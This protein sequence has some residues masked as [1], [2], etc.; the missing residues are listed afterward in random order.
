MATRAVATKTKAPALSMSKRQAYMLGIIGEAEKVAKIQNISIGMEDRMSS[1][2]LCLDLMLGKG[3]LAPGMYTFSGGEQ[4]CK[5]TTQLVV[6][7]ASVYQK[8]EM[9]V[10]WDAE[11]SS[12]SS[13]DYVQ[14]VVNTVLRDKRTISV[15]D[16]FGVKNKKGDFIQLPVV[17]YQDTNSLEGFFDFFAALLRRL[18]DKRYED[19]QWWYIFPKDTKGMERAKA[20]DLEID[21]ARSKANGA[22]YAPAEDGSP[23]ALILNDGWAAM[24]PEAMDEEEKK[25]GLGL[26]ARKFAEHLPRVKGKLRAKRVILIGTNQ[27]KEKPMAFGD[28]RY[29]SGGNSLRFNSDCRIWHTARALSGVPYKPK[30]KGMIEE[31]DSVEFPGTKDVY[32]YVSLEARKNKLGVP[33]RTTWIKVWISDGEGKARGLCPVFDTFHALVETGQISGKLTGARDK[34]LL[35]VNSLGEAKKNINWTEFKTLILGTRKEMDTVLEKIG[36]KTGIG[37]RAGLF[38]MSRRGLLEELY[39]AR[40]TGANRLTSSATESAEDLVDEEDE[41]DNGED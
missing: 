9:R 6:M 40:R 39:V 33:N 27:L 1:G 13:T 37:I 35:N 41:T 16:L 25:A 23:Q 19:G 28:P 31:E 4:S 2:M 11:N 20:M 29:E 14:N 21:V 38:R 10:L 3:G 26:L 18:P 12:G 36:Y 30:G 8:V 7:A 5:T 24:L 34:L 32:R 17:Y 15:E 22:I